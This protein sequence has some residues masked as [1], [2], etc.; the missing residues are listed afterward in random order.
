MVFGSEVPGSGSS[1]RNPLTGKPSDDVLA[2]IEAFD[3]L[4]D[5]QRMKIVHDNPRKVFPLLD[6]LPLFG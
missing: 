3:F 6:K 2:T 4:S 5:E 1:Q